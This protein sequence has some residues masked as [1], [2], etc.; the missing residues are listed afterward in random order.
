MTLAA[1]SKLRPYEIVAPLD[2]GGMG[3]VE[4]L[5]FGVSVTTC[6]PR[7]APSLLKVA[8]PWTCSREIGESSTSHR[9]EPR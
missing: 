2:A 6:V 4:P 3:E 9:R 1:E 5:L 8:V 7:L